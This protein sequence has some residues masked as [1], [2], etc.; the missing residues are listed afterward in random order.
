M[1]I[2]D[3]RTLAANAE[4][5][6]KKLRP[7]QHLRRNPVIA[8]RSIRALVSPDHRSKRFVGHRAD[9]TKHVVLGNRIREREGA[10]KLGLGVNAANHNGTDVAAKKEGAAFNLSLIH[11]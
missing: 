11:I 5:S 7:D 10:E 2:R 4:Q 9:L 3:R 6:L 8:I 1:C